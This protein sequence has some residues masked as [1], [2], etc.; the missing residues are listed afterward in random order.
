MSKRTQP[1]GAAAVEMA[2]TMV[3]LIPLIF[4]ALFLQDFVYYRLNGQETLVAAAFDFVTPNYQEAAPGIDGMNRLKYCDHTAAYDSYD[5][6]FECEGPSGSGGPGGPGVGVSG[7]AAKLGHHHAT[8]AHQCWIGGGQELECPISKGVDRAMLPSA[9]PFNTFFVSN[10]NR[11]GMATCSAQLKVTNYVI[12]RMLSSETG[13]WLWSKKKLTDR[14]Q[15]GANGGGAEYAGDEWVSDSDINGAHSDFGSS[16]FA[17][18]EGAGDGET[19]MGSWLFSKEEMSVLVDP[20]ALTDPNLAEADAHEGGFITSFLR[21]GMIPGGNDPHPILT[22]T[23]NY[24]NHYARTPADDGMEWHGD[25]VDKEFLDS[26][27]G[28]DTVG[29][30]LRSVPVTWKKNKP[31]PGFNGTQGQGMASGYADSRAPGANRPNK[32]P[33]Y[34]GPQSN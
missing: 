28:Y 16:D 7:G 13:G 33:Q 18:E 25:M 24:Y 27:S 8:G 12:P 31:K 34:W 19:A 3:V 29:D 15:I 14:R 4:Y 2:I 1:R 17:A 20:W 22:R 30:Q 32:Y 26:W 21:P 23:G 9:M 11:G 5:R 10:W 6:D